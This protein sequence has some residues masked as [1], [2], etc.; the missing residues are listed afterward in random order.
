MIRVS[1]AVAPDEQ[2]AVLLMGFVQS[3]VRQVMEQRDWDGVSR[4]QAKVLVA[5]PADGATISALAAGLGM[6]KQACGQFVGALVASGHL[7]VSSDPADRRARRVHR[8]EAGRRVATSV[9]AS[10]RELEQDWARLVGPRRWAT[11]RAVLSELADGDWPDATS[12]GVAS[13]DVTGR[14]SA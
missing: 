14:S 10:H 6:T 13:S 3:R 1:D 9:T 12:S 4:A 11:F 8:T 2:H 5:V 7:R